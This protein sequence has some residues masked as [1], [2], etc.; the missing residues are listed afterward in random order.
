M[1]EIWR[2]QMKRT[3]N[4]WTLVRHSGRPPAT[5]EASSS[6]TE[7]SLQNEPPLFS[8]L[9]LW[10]KNYPQPSRLGR[11]ASSLF[12]HQLLSR[13]DFCVNNLPFT[14]GFA[15]QTK[16]HLTTIVYFEFKDFNGYHTTCLSNLPFW[17]MRVCF[18]KPICHSKLK[19][20]P[21]DFFGYVRHLTWRFHYQMLYQMNPTRK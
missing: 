4:P 15:S 13:A 14:V 18:C 9:T 2:R 12:W 6:V 11:I 5:G 19:I 7:N 20:P 1:G 10:I 8:L 21:P 17:Y 16:S 3:T